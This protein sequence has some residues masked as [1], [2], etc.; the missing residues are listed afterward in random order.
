[1]ALNV[2]VKRRF[3]ERGSQNKVGLILLLFSAYALLV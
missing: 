3:D 1:M 2:P